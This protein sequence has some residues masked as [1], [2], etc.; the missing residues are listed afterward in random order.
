MHLVPHE[1]QQASRHM[2]I[3]LN[4]VAHLQRNLIF[5]L[6]SLFNQTPRIA[7]VDRT[8]LPRVSGSNS[9]QVGGS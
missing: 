4:D 5:S 1:R 2:E 3:C 8:I 6:L 7:E 9:S